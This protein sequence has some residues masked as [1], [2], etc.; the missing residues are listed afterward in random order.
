MSEAGY[1]KDEHYQFL[2]KYFP[3]NTIKLRFQALWGDMVKVLENTGIE[4]K[5]RIDEES[6]QMVVLDYFADVARIKD[7]QDISRINVNKIYSYELFWFLRRHPI[8]LIEAVPDSFDINEKVALGI[9]LPR[10]LK[11][12]DIPYTKKAQDKRIRERLNIFINL[13]FYNFKYR[14]Y[15]PQSLELLIEAFLC[16][17]NCAYINKGK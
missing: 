6:F 17:A 13:L 7:F 11:E 8:Q 4:N 16:G 12:A 15:T 5:F 10:I 9:F 14:T 1:V 2:L 3:A